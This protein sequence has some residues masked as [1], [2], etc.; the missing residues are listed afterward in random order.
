MVGQRR[1][2]GARYGPSVRTTAVPPTDPSAYSFAH[3]IRTRFA[4]TDAMGVIHHGAYPAYLEEARIAYLRAMDHPYAE[5]RG[6]GLELAVVELH[7]RYRR[8]LRFDDVVDVHVGVAGA[9]RSTLQLV[10]L[11]AV[12]DEPRATAISVHGAVDGDGRPRRLPS[13]LRLVPRID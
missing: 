6:E 13:W 1:W 2:R 8:P 5:I 3:P 12:D 11:L 7:L 10:Y 4:E 9:S